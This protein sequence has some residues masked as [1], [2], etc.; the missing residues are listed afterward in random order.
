MPRPSGGRAHIGRFMFTAALVISMVTGAGLGNLFSQGESA[1]FAE[2]IAAS[3]VKASAPIA[4]FVRLQPS[5]YTPYGKAVRPIQRGTPATI[6]ANSR[7]VCDVAAGTVTRSVTVLDDAGKSVS[8]TDVVFTVTRSDRP[9][10]QLV[11]D[12]TSRDG[13]ALV[14]VVVPVGAVAPGDQAG[15]QITATVETPT[16]TAAVDFTI[17]TYTCHAEVN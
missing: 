8:G 12:V 13:Q 14:T 6:S 15:Y 11:G 2:P 5:T 4:F 3:P 17:D 10:P 9:E 1:A 16:G 7:Q